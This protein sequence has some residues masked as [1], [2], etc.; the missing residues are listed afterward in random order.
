V[1]DQYR[2]AGVA[3][4]LR[5]LGVPVQVLPMTDTTKAAAYSELRARLN[6]VELE[7]YEEP[8]LLAELRRLRTRYAAGRATVFNPRSGDSHGD[9]AQALALWGHPLGGVADSTR[10]LAVALADPSSHL[11]ARRAKAP[12]CRAF[13]SSGGRI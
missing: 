9:V 7:L 8:V 3:D 10:V 12:L 4:R 5:R 2:A 11:R 6:A 13:V 1:T